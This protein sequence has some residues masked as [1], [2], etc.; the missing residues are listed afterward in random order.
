MQVFFEKS[1]W[2]GTNTSFFSL[3]YRK[4]YRKTLVYQGFER[5]QTL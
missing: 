1:L 4:S 2:D 3:R 5:F